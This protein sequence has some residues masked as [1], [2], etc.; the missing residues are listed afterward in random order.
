[1]LA[2]AGRAVDAAAVDT[3]TVDRVVAEWLAST[4]AP[5]A[6]IAIVRGG[7]LTYAQAYGDARLSP[8]AG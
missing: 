4:G 7:R 2:D 1:M 8:F 5:S 6:S 3:A